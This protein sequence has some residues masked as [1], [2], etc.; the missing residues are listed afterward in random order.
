MPARPGRPGRL[1]KAAGADRAR[2]LEAGCDDYHPKPVDFSGLLAQID[3]V[4]LARDD[5]APDAAP[6]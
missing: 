4:L 1:E 5:Q 6:A 2:T 3:A